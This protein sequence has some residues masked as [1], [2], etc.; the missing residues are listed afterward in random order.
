MESTRLVWPAL[1]R[2]DNMSLLAELS[3]HARHTVPRTACS[4]CHQALMGCVLVAAPDLV[5][6]MFKGA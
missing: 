6:L 1:H 3:A 4:W 5:H 2:V